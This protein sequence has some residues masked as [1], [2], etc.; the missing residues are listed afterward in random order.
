MEPRAPAF[1]LL[2]GAFLAVAG[3][4]LAAVSGPPYLSSEGV[5][6]WMVVFAAALFTALLAL[7]F[8][9]EQRLRTTIPDRDRRW[10][11]VVPIWGGA[12][13]AVLVIGLL[14]GTAAGFGGD[15]LV[16]SA[17]LLAAIEAGIV[18]VALFFVLLS[19]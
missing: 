15:S 13:L 16:G 1:A 14:C 12:A 18:A 3:L 19:G 7:P 17:G 5:N 4:T 6:G 11:R 8:V 10:D 9:L 2:A